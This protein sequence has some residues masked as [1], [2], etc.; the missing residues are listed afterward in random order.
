MRTRRTACPAMRS[1]S[2]STAGCEAGPSSR[3]GAGPPGESETHFG[4]RSVPESLKQGM[5]KGVFS[6]VASS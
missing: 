5:V 4:F 6:S 2:T 3:P 1:L